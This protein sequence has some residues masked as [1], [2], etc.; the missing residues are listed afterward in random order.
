MFDSL[1]LDTVSLPH[2]HYHWLWG[3]QYSPK[4]PS[5]NLGTEVQKLLNDEARLTDLIKN[6]TNFYLKHNTAVHFFYW[7]FNINN[8]TY[9]AYLLAACKGHQNYLY[10]ALEKDSSM[11][12][13]PF[14]IIWGATLTLSI[15]Y[16]AKQIHRLLT[17]VTKKPTETTSENTSSK[18]L[19]KLH[20]T[21]PTTQQQ[22]I[23]QNSNAEAV[24]VTESMQPHLAVLGI[25]LNP[26]DLLYLSL[27]KST[28]KT[29]YLA[30][31]PDKPGGSKEKF[32]RIRDAVD[33][34]APIISSA[35]NWNDA[36]IEIRAMWKEAGVKISAMWNEVRSEAA[37]IG[38]EATLVKAETTLVR[39]E[40][41][42]IKAEAAAIKTEAAELKAKCLK[43]IAERDTQHAELIEIQEQVKKLQEQRKEQEQNTTHSPSFSEAGAPGMFAPEIVSSEGQDATPKI[44]P[45]ASACT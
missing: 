19:V 17:F 16:A 24:N 15:G 4:V 31:H 13:T 14:Q 43:A 8:S 21:I 29:L 23:P 34:L 44:E 10:R 2:L 9:H 33:A 41:S 35:V 7:L 3:L 1:E 42:A 27:F 20:E 11:I 30:S 6:Q 26:G 37:N 22:A 45:D 5:E 32:C 39:A 25:N 12:P 40:A 18:A 28:C 38:A 36:L